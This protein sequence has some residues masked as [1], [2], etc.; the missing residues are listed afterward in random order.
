MTK[1]RLFWRWASVSMLTLN[2]A[3]YMLHLLLAQRRVQSAGVYHQPPMHYIFT[4]NTSKRWRVFLIK[5]SWKISR[6]NLIPILH[7]NYMHHLQ[8]LRE[9]Y[10]YD[11]LLQFCCWSIQQSWERR[12]LHVKSPVAAASFETWVNSIPEIK[13]Y[14]E[15]YIWV[16]H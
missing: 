12:W 14:R 13:G 4:Y 3:P 7:S 10:G 2:A 16:E 1:F 5:K 15:T 6:Q 11:S 9:M 8:H